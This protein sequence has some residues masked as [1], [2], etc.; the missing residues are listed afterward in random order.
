MNLDESLLVL[1]SPVLV[2]DPEF[3][4]ALEEITSLIPVDRDWGAQLEYTRAYQLSV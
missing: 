3:Y 2:D 1:V 4:L